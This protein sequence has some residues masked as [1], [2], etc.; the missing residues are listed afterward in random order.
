MQRQ[1][2][3]RHIQRIHGDGLRLKRYIWQQA[4]RFR[5]DIHIRDH[6]D[7]L[8]NFHNAADGVHHQYIHGQCRENRT[9]CRGHSLV[10]RRLKMRENN[11]LDFH[12]FSRRLSNVG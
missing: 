6:E 5:D 2:P 10:H 12:E 7:T 4:D 1:R 9:R 3:D 11:R 8:Q